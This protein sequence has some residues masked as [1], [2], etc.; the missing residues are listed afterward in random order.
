MSTESTAKVFNALYPEEL[1]ERYNAGERDFPRINLLRA[2]LERILGPTTNT[3]LGEAEWTRAGG[4][5]PLWDDFHNPLN[6]RFEWDDYGA[7]VPIECDDIL[8]DRDLSKAN[9][10]GINLEG[11]YLYPVNFSGANLHR[12]NLRNA[13]LHS[14]NL[15]GADLSYADLRRA[16]VR[17]DLQ[18][19]NLYMAKLERCTLKG[20]D[21]RGADLRRA[22]LQE[23]NLA[24]TDLRTANLS[25]AHFGRTMLN[26]ARLQEVDFCDVNL[27]SVYVTG[28]TI[29]SSKW[30]EFLKALCIHLRQAGAG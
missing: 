22:K 26:G 30:S 6:R 19:A 1:L 18:S 11:S 20:C 21:L 12:A 9:L 28:V 29:D 8:P 17:G 16:R 10:T 27:D 15:S 7:F 25:K 2:E 4:F 13:I 24:N 14:V 3:T 5:N 23:T